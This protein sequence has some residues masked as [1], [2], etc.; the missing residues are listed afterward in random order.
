MTSQPRQPQGRPDGGQFKKGSTNSGSGG[1]PPEIN[2]ALT[3][4][5]DELY[6]WGAEDVDANGTQPDPDCEFDRMEDVANWAQPYAGDHE[7]DFDMDGVAD[8]ISM[9]DRQ[10]GRLAVRSMFTGTGGGTS[11]ALNLA[12]QAN[13]MTATDKERDTARLRLDKLMDADRKARYDRLPEA[14][15]DRLTVERGNHAALRARAYNPMGG[16]GVIVRRGALADYMREYHEE[17]HRRG[18]TS[19]EDGREWYSPE[20]AGMEESDPVQVIAEER[21]CGQADVLR[22][23][24]RLDREEN[25]WEEV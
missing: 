2:D 14:E 7:R 20:D 19:S 3:D 1:L 12:F 21:G 17:F 18:W 13:D 5:H 8:T 11:A 4:A 24:A 16:G 6:G 10:T 25:G 22:S 9:F 15:Q 23:L